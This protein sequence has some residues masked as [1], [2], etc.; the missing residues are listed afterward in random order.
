M[1]VYLFLKCATPYVRRTHPRAMPLAMMTMKT[2]V[3]GFPIS[4]NFLWVWGSALRTFGPLWSSANNIK[5]IN[6]PKSRWCVHFALWG[7]KI[8]ISHVIIF[9]APRTPHTVAV[10]V[11]IA[12]FSLNPTLKETVSRILA[13]FRHRKWPANWVTLSLVNNLLKQRRNVSITQQ[14]QRFF[15]NIAGLNSF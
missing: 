1:S 3:H 12:W 11:S 8:R 15:L 14:I 6:G 9:I 10:I 13:K 5:P 2:Q 7:H 4:V